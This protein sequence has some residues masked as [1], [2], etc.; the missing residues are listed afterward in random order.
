[1]NDEIQAYVDRYSASGV[2]LVGS[3]MT[4]CN[5]PPY[6]SSTNRQLSTADLATIIPHVM[7]YTKNTRQDGSISNHSARLWDDRC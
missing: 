6:P 7:I 3:Y 2:T 5:V 1:M 4:N